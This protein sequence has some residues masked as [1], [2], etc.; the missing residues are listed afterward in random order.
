MHISRLELAFLFA[1][2]ANVGVSS[3]AGHPKYGL[4]SFLPPSQQE[5]YV[6]HAIKLLDEVEGQEVPTS[7]LRCHL[8]LLIAYYLQSAC[9]YEEAWQTC[10]RAVTA[11]HNCRLFYLN[12]W[13]HV[14]PTDQYTVTVLQGEVPYLFNWMAYAME[15]FD[16]VPFH[17]NLPSSIALPYE[18]DDPFDQAFM[19]QKATSSAFA[20]KA[21]RLIEQSEDYPPK[22]L[23]QVAIQL[24]DEILGYEKFQHPRLR[25]ASQYFNIPADDRSSVYLATYTFLTKGG[26][27]LQRWRMAQTFYER[28][29]L[30]IYQHMYLSSARTVLQMLPLV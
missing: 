14:S 15:S 29:P 22:K 25:D 20:R 16:T 5:A 7:S 26:L 12:E 13:Q 19:R 30:D 17:D 2:L 27:M 18:P 8:L 11:A 6:C 28:H 23:L 9:R 21:S 3:P 4:D 24:D 1:V 10:K